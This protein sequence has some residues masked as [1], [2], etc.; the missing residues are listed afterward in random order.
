VALPL[1]AT[2]IPPRASSLRFGFSHPVSKLLKFFKLL[3]QCQCPDKAKSR[4]MI[5]SLDAVTHTP[6]PNIKRA[7]A[8]TVAES[9]AIVESK[10][11]FRPT[12]QY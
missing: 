5:A 7:N 6:T 12:E 10:T 1:F 8:I 9:A 3:G 2:L 4:R 11:Q